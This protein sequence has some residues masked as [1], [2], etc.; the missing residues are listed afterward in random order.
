MDKN[1][2]DAASDL[3]T[4]PEN[5]Q[6]KTSLFSRLVRLAGKAAR[7][8][9]VDALSSMA[10]GLFAS[11]IIGLI[12]KQIFSMISLPVVDELAG[13]IEEITAARSPV[14]GAAI[15]VAIAAGLKN[16]PLVIYTAAVVGAIGYAVSAGG[17]SAGPV[18]AYIAVLVGA[19][20][21]GR[22]AGKTKLDILLVP[23]VT[24]LTGAI[25]AMLV[26]PPIARMMVAIG[27]A[28][29]ELTM[30]RPLPMGMAVSAVMG[31]L[32]TA[33]ISSA[34]IAIMLGLSGLAAGAATA[35]CSA[36]MIG[37]AVASFR[38]NRTAGLIAQGVGTSMLQIG[39]ILRRPQILLPAV[40][41]SLITGPLATTVFKMEN[42][43]AGAGMGTSGLVGP[44]TTWAAMDGQMATGRLVLFIALLYF[45]FPAIIA[46]ITSEILRA[47]K[48]IR[49]G[50]M[51]LSL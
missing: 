23:A 2:K 30:L 17:I 37:F 20:L 47:V 44:L 1:H 10:L 8:Y 39:N 13:L 6:Q 4:N 3:Q 34:A 32:L 15:G 51:K 22:V 41:A 29:N 42:V 43:A 14:I 24:I 11:L 35:G 48:W 7:R 38:E 26:G 12:L 9:L 45:V 31:L 40:A 18:G 46:L 27:Q 16:K 36:H 49:P 21:G 25:T 50:D 28:I 33:P 19:E 5:H